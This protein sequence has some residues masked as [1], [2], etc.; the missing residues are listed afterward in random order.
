MEVYL[1]LFV[2][3]KHNDW[4]KL[5]SMTKLPY[6]NAKNVSTGY[7]PFK[8]NCSYHLR[9]FFKKDTN[10]CSKFKLIDKLL[11]K[12]QELMAVCYKNIYYMQKLQK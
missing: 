8:L 2:N 11:A 12:L 4:A 9:V 3:F 6:N 7:T 10:F 5:L 1:Q